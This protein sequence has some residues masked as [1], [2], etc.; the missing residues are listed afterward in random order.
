MRDLVRGSR[1]RLT[2]TPILPLPAN[3][4]FFFAV[5]CRLFWR[6]V[7]RIPIVSSRPAESQRTATASATLQPSIARR[8]ILIGGKSCSAKNTRTAMQ[9][10]TPRII[11]HCSLLQPE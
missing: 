4:T 1:Q 11:R 8:T 9:H 3:R 7:I 10:A 5:H 6:I 2:L